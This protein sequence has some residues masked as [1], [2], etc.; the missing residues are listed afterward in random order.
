[1]SADAVAAIDDIGQR[2][3]ASRYRAVAPDG[4]EER[5]VRATW[6][7]IARA[8]AG[9]EPASGPAWQER[10]LALLEDFR[11][12]PGGRIQAGCGLANASL[13]NCFV[14][15]PPVGDASSLLSCIEE[16]MRTMLAGG[17][18]GCDF[19]SVAP[20][21][22]ASNQPASIRSGP[23]PLLRLWDELCG[24]VSAGRVRHGAMLGSLRCDHPDIEAFIGA[25][26][27]PGVLPNFNLSVLVTDEFMGTLHRDAEW[28]LVFPLRGHAA[29]DDR[30]VMRRWPGS[31]QVVPCRVYRVV[32]ARLLGT[33]SLRVTTTTPNRACSSL[34]AC[35]I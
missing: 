32:P 25:K 9:V 34:T 4:R 21:G 29:A 11:F 5:D 3:W 12:L 35:S 6:R 20:A 22:Q 18:V 19:S 33:R 30:I 17:G 2:V 26:S 27:L 15:A 14:M 1:M 13:F 28:P 10:F 24:I 23:V 31:S 7:R 8:L 16:L